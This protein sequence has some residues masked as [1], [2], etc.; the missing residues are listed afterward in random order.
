M[1]ELIE[2]FNREQS[3]IIQY[4]FLEL[5]TKKISDVIIE[6]IYKKNR[7]L[8]DAISNI[9]IVNTK[10]DICKLNRYLSQNKESLGIELYT[11]L[12]SEIKEIS[13]DYKWSKSKD[14]RIILSI[15]EWLEKVRTIFKQDFHYDFIYMGRSFIDPKI[16]I[17]GGFVDSEQMKK[18][19]ID[20]FQSLNPPV[21]IL[22][23][24]RLKSEL[25]TV[26]L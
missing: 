23:K 7:R 20:Y 3:T 22:F 5:L 2:E 16:L 13:N 18:D 24:I 14:G 1:K 9:S 8:G 26:P 21:E 19:F 15:E 25:Q 17:I 11:E 12:Y 10:D 4:N 6:D